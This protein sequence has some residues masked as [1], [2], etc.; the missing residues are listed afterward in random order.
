MVTPLGVEHTLY[1]AVN[2]KAREDSMSDCCSEFP[3]D[4][5]DGIEGPVLFQHLPLPD[6]GPLSDDLI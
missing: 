3:D 1:S 2:E 5:S 6:T 4:I